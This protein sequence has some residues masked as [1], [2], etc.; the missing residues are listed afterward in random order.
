MKFKLLRSIE[1]QANADSQQT[2]YPFLLVLLFCLLL[3]CQRPLVVEELVGFLT[4]IIDR[5]HQQSQILLQERTKISQKQKGTY[6]PITFYQQNA[7]VSVLQYQV[8]NKHTS[9]IFIV[10]QGLT[11]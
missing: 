2:I 6:S 9:S 11:G 8:F 1:P 4:Q 7:V 3:L 10:D 5:V